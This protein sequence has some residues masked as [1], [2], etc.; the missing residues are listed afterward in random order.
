MNDIK[1]NEQIALL[2][3]RKGI[4]QETL[5][6]LLGVTNQT[7]SK[8]ESGQCFPDIQLL[9]QI[10]DYFEVSV[11]ELLGHTANSGLAAHSLALKKY[12]SKC[13][14]SEC[15]NHAYRLVAQLHE[16]TLS[17]GDRNPLPWQEKNYAAESLNQWGISACCEPEGN[18]V[19]C[20][21]LIL[22]TDNKAWRR[23]KNKEIREI[24][25]TLKIFSD[26][27][28]LKA[29]LVLHEL[30]AQSSDKYLSASEIAKAANID[31]AETESILSELPLT[32]SENQEE[33]T[34][35]ID[36]ASAWLPSVLELI[37]L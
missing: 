2:R 26:E 10:A 14:E 23:L 17:H 27:N 32:I 3:H 31:L 29:F 30:T 20:R 7:I 9:P 22:F 12:F 21:D 37:R 11:D 35:R 28:T 6:R 36:G 5:A 8:W 18:T 4:T 34:Y 13:P 24:A 33:K 25:Y 19:R 16:I 15:F 1:L